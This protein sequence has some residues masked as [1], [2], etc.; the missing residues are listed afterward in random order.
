MVFGARDVPFAEIGRSSAWI[1]SKDSVEFADGSPEVVAVG[2]DGV[3]RIRG[4]ADDGNVAVI[5][6]KV[7]L[8]GDEFSKFRWGM[9]FRSEQDKHGVSGVG[10]GTAG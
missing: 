3:H 9:V 10:G 6:E 7:V 4:Q 1:T 2:S 5:I 8:S